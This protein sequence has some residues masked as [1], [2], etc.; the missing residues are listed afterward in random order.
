MKVGDYVRTIYG[1]KRI[2]QIIC[3]QDVRFDNTDGFDESLLNWHDYDGISM[4]SHKWKEIVIGE[5]KEKPIDLIKE[6][7]YVNGHKVIYT[8]GK[9]HKQVFVEYVNMNDLLEIKPQQIKSIVTREQFESMEYKVG[10]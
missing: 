10:E 7:D 1:I 9:V 6:G 3:G 5:P 2:D 8:I 4:Y